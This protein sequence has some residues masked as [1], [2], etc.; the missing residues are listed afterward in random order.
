MTQPTMT[1]RTTKPRYLEDLSPGERLTAG[2]MELSE[3]DT[4]GFAERYDPQPMHTDQAAAT[5]GPFHGLIASGWQT[6]AI[7]MRLIIEA[8]PFGGGPVLGLGVDELRW[9]APLRPGDR[10]SAELEIVS[11]TPS[12]SNPGFGVVRVK[13]TARNQNGE[14]VLSMFPSLW[15]PRRP[16]S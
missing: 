10:V 13:V 12:R 8:K 1:P 4:V 3:A 7:V 2:P 5:R 6:T 14:I 9:P 16:A 15:V 11:I